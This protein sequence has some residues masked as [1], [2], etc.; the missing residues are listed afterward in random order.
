[1][2]VFDEIGN[3]EGAIVSDLQV[4]QLATIRRRKLLVAADPRQIQSDVRRSPIQV[5]RS[6]PS[7]FRAIGVVLARRLALIDRHP[8]SLIPTR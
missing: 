4:R 5:G 7:V 2:G 8:Q 3:A 1:V 6:R